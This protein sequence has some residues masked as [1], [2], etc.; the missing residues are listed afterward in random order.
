[1]RLFEHTDC[2]GRSIHLSSERLKHILKHPEMVECLY[3]LPR[4]L[5]KPTKLTQHGTVMY[6]YGHYKR[7]QAPYLRVVVKYVK[8]HRSISST[9]ESFISIKN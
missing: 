3:D 4:I 5:K 7:S 1:M 2:T 8:N 9:I 6:Y